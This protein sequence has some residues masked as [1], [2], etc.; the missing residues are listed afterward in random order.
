[1]T[2]EIGVCS[3][4]LEPSSPEDLVAKV[5]ACGL[6][7]I[8]LALDP[9]RRGSWRMDATARALR[10][11]GIGI[12]SGMMEMKGED[13]TSLETIAR[14]G[15]VLPDE[16]WEE[17]LAAARRDAEIAAALAL[18]LVTFHAGVIP[19]PNEGRRRAVVLERVRAVARCFEERGI[20]VALETGQ[21][22]AADLWEALRE[23]PTVG[24]N[25]DAANMIL[26]GKGDPAEA[27]RLL[28]PRIVQVHVKDAIPTKTP[29]TWGT[30][31]PQGTGAVGWPAFAGL[32][33][34]LVPG[35]NLLIEREGGSDRAGDVRK[36]RLLLEKALA[37]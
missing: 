24:V 9:I 26:Y 23:L 8:Q 33:R 15:G 31:V 7:R 13:Y 18:P 3:W 35:R 21:E 16:T 25:F 2:V 6:S 14:T 36:A 1:M 28:A 12:L 29:G 27:V 19:H 11:A 10:E 32:L 30:E 34:S 37:A 17:N 5:R 22:R 20:E 4:S